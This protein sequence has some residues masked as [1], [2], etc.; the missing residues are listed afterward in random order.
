MSPARAWII[1]VMQAAGIVPRIDAAGNIFARVRR[2]AESS[3]RSCSDRTSTRCRPAATSTATS[4]SL[5]ALE[6][7]QAVQAAQAC[8]TRHPL[9]MVVWAHEEGMAF[10]IGT[11]RQPHRR[12]RPQ[13]G[14]M[15]EV[16]NGMRRA[17]AIRK[18]GGDPDRIEDARSRPRAPGTR[19]VELHIEQG[20]TLDKARRPD[21]RR[22]RHRRDPS[23]RRGRSTG[24][25]NHAGTTPMDERQDA[26]VAASQ[27]TLAVREIVTRA[28][29]AGR[30]A[31]SAASRSSR[32][33]RT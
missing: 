14:D 18:I 4:G 13:A 16:W 19:Y 10:G 31:P 23:L 2:A 5:A 15:D 28:A 20:G 6:V 17:D 9:E 33:R 22:R 25:A 11:R 21:R 8:T 7:I 27:L 30:S 3:R 12:R 24:L 29:R 26:L 1:D 32:T